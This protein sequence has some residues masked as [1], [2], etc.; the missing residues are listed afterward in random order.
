[1]LPFSGSSLI[2]ICL[3]K[4]SVLSLSVH[5]GS[6]SICFLSPAVCVSLF[7]S[8]FRTYCSTGQTYRVFF[9]RNC[10]EINYSFF[11]ATVLLWCYLFKHSHSPVTTSFLHVSSTCFVPLSPLE[12]G[13]GFLSPRW[14][15]GE[16]SSLPLEVGGGF[17]S[18]PGSWGRVS[19]IHISTLALHTHTP[20]TQCS[21]NI[22]TRQLSLLDSQLLDLLSHLSSRLPG[23]QSRPPPAF[24]L[25][26]YSLPEWTTSAPSVLVPI[27]RADLTSVDKG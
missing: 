1:M 11:C 25:L 20:L 12:V 19:P 13:G 17:L 16:G 21:A 10:M 9:I 4:C 2:L 5:T 15:L 24:E 27:L 6:R 18:P 22:C 3:S 26:E 23:S 8:H 14:K 7:I